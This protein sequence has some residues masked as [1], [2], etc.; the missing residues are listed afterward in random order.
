MEKPLE[1]ALDCSTRGLSP[2]SFFLKTSVSLLL[3][4]TSP[5]KR[6]DGKLSS[7]SLQASSLSSLGHTSSD[8]ESPQV[9]SPRVMYEDHD[10]L[11]SF[12]STSSIPSS[13]YPSNGSRSPR[14]LFKSQSRSKARSKSA[15]K[16]S[17]E[18][19][20]H[21]MSEPILSISPVQ[22]QLTP[23]LY[24][25]GGNKSKSKVGNFMEG[26]AR[27]LKSKKK[28]RPPSIYPEDCSLDPRKSALIS[29]K[30][31]QKHFSMPTVFHIYYSK[32]KNMQLY[33]SVLV[34][35]SSTAQDVIK[36]SLERYGMKFMSPESFS[37]FEVIG[38]WE[39]IAVEY[40]PAYER[41]LVLPPS[42]QSPARQSQK[43]TRAFEEFVECYTRK[44]N[45][46][47][48]PYEVQ[49]FHEPQSGYT[50]RF[51][52]RSCSNEEGDGSKSQDQFVPSTP[53]FG[54]TS[55]DINNRR[56]RSKSQDTFDFSI[57]EDT[58][59]EVM[60]DGRMKQ[61]P[62]FLHSLVDC[63]SP[64]SM[65]ILT[66]L[67]PCLPCCS[68]YPSITSGVFLL[69][70]QLVPIK[71]EFLIYSL[72][73]E[74][75]IVRNKNRKDDLQAN[76]LQNQVEVCIDA[77]DSKPGVVLCT[78][79][80]DKQ[81]VYSI[82][83]VN[84]N[85]SIN[86]ETVS[87]VV[88]LC[89][90]DLIKIGNTHLFMFQNHST[91]IDTH[92]YQWIPK[93]ANRPDALRELPDQRHT[94]L[95]SSQTVHETTSSVNT[96]VIDEVQKPLSTT[97]QVVYI[98]SRD[99]ICS[100]PTLQEVEGGGEQVNEQHVPRRR[101]SSDVSGG[102]R[103]YSKSRSNQRQ[104]QHKQHLQTSGQRSRANNK[105]GAFPADRRLMFSYNMAEED[106][107]LEL[108]IDDLNPTSVIF[109]LAPSYALSMCM[110]YSMRCS[111]PD[112]AS[113]LAC[114]AVEKIQKKVD[115]VIDQVSS[116]QPQTS[117]YVNT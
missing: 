86:G 112:T 15:Q 50:R 32:A 88:K 81:S 105:L 117:E 92:N 100:L 22:Q 109:S 6:F 67:Q 80:R 116:W 102:Q 77:C 48:K 33:K 89:H 104:Q 4:S 29:P 41:S 114:K 103:R 26:V 49:F 19:S 1:I 84:C 58:S 75:F 31:A 99:E 10:S 64:D 47:E 110:E 78:I 94:Q 13:V 14:S 107:I 16:L 11:Y 60:V 74:Q 83:P 106:T 61:S 53:L 59:D 7:L 68:F 73:Y 85:L 71:Q 21:K 101:S 91:S 96:T 8:S 3:T 30:L 43:P 44:L 38:K 9:G 34:L 2:P 69:N 54:S 108:L 55:H 51:E 27:S 12:S 97:A 45:S 115:K 95:P 39:E 56:S 76:N 28:I 17:F 79:K 93:H 52:L 36:Q 111:G 82:D 70:L 63:S 37:L 90:G 66:P 98:T 62:G 24:R 5:Q 113:R 42:D 35:E 20:F 25:K 65:D 46:E 72:L 40:E 23:E 57:E 18:N 87:K